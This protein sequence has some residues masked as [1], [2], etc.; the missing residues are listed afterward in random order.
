MHDGSELIGPVEPL[1]DPLTDNLSDCSSEGLLSFLM[2]SY[3]VI[4]FA[5]A[6]TWQVPHW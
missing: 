2:Q 4:C 1:S 5:A 6:H 3:S